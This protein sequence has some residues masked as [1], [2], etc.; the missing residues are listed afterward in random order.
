[1]S[2]ECQESPTK[3]GRGTQAGGGEMSLGKISH[4]WQ[5]LDSGQAVLR[6]KKLQQ[7]Y[8]SQER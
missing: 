2:A 3:K 8:K 7:K 6:R 4:H 5:K 1:M